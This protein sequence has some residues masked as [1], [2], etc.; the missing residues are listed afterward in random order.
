MKASQKRSLENQHLNEFQCG[1]PN[2]AKTIHNFKERL[3][4]LNFD[5]ANVSWEFLEDWSTGNSTVLFEG[6]VLISGF[7]P[8]TL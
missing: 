1:K 4:D 7:I 2:E 3:K 5:D 8:V 6:H